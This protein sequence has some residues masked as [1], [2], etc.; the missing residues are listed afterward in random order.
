[1]RTHRLKKT[2]SSTQTLS[3]C[4]SNLKF[5]T[6]QDLENT[7]GAWDL[8]GQEDTKRYPDMQNEFFERAATGLSSRGAMLRFLFLGA[9]PATEKWHASLMLTS[10]AQL[11]R[12][13]LQCQ[14]LPT[15]LLALCLLIAAT[16]HDNAG[17]CFRALDS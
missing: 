4:T 2:Y 16:L 8:Y 3:F 1:M 15:H 7:V 14:A 6:V 17:C 11:V 13:D 9:L 10:V 5:V 12:C